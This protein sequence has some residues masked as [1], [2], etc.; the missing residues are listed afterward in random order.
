VP[1]ETKPT[2]RRR[3]APARK[4]DGKFTETPPTEMEAALPKKELSKYSPK[5]LV[6]GLSSDTAGKYSKKSKIGRPGL[7][8]TRTIIN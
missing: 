2:P 4:A 6:S 7:G 8:K 1:E 5:P 3:R